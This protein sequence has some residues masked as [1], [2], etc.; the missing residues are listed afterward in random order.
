MV[1]CYDTRV[2]AEAN[3]LPEE[4]P[5]RRHAWLSVL[6]WLWMACARPI[7]TVFPEEPRPD[8]CCEEPDA[9]PVEDGGGDGSCSQPLCTVGCEFGEQ[10]LLDEQGMPLFTYD[11]QL[12]PNGR[13]LITGSQGWGRPE[14]LVVWLVDLGERPTVLSRV[15]LT[16]EWLTVGGR[17]GVDRALLVRHREDWT[18]DALWAT[19]SGDSVDL[20]NPI[21]V[22]EAC[23][24]ARSGPVISSDR[25]VVGVERRDE[26]VVEVA[27]NQGDGW[28]WVTSDTG[29]SVEL[30]DLGDRILVVYLQ[31]GF[32]VRQV[33]SW[34]GDIL[35]PPTAVS[36]ESFF[37]GDLGA[38]AQPAGG[39]MV[40]GFQP[41]DEKGDIVGIRLD[42]RGDRVWSR[43]VPRAAGF[44]VGLSACW[45]GRTHLALWGEMTG[46]CGVGVHGLVLVDV[47]APPDGHVLAG[48]GL[49]S[50]PIRHRTASYS[51]WPVCVFDSDRA[52]VF[53]GGWQ[54]ETF[55][56]L[57]GRIVSPR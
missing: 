40:W 35:S 15:T 52:V 26:A 8:A 10:V 37:V 42:A 5:M 1:L 12:M 24:P 18:T 27:L 6:P 34:E 53:W 47:D 57:Y 4:R 39:A 19:V 23:Y 33:L 20:S 49:V 38:A 41:E 56:G 9:G 46:P 2:A 17:Q 50:E 55:Y 29:E 22:C 25:M 32:V 30:L 51:I 45:Q 44:A 31:A 36:D 21:P 7:G 14:S 3:G 54:E 43:V 28:H 13:A 48:P 16:G 11:A